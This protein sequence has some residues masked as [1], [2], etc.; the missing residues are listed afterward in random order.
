LTRRRD[1]RRHRELAVI[2]KIWQRR[3]E[4]SQ[5]YQLKIMTR[6]KLLEL[7]SGLAGR[8]LLLLDI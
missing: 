7:R 3:K 6:K 1:K 2:S 8:R 5:L 4:M